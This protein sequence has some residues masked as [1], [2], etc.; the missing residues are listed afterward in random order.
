[1]KEIECSINEMSW[2]T[3]EYCWNMLLGSQDLYVSDYCDDILVHIEEMLHRSGKLGVGWR[4]SS[5]LGRYSTSHLKNRS[6]EAHMF[7]ISCLLAT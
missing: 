6:V 3:A 2:A 7:L 4:G 1:M 5:I